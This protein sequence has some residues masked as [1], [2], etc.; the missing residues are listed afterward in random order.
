MQFKMQCVCVQRL[1][2]FSVFLVLLYIRSLDPFFRSVPAFSV[3]CPPKRE[4]DTATVDQNQTAPPGAVVMETETT[5]PTITVARS[6]KEE[7]DAK[8][9]GDTAEE[10]LSPP[11]PSSRRKHPP[12]LVAPAT[13]HFIPPQ[14]L[15]GRG[16]PEKDLGSRSLPL[17][18]QPEKAEETEGGEGKRESTH[19]QLNYNQLMKEVC[20]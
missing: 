4:E 7:D 19:S 16:E 11:Q 15:M 5:P 9:E 20:L 3:L 14:K 8:L 1:L 17:L 12:P 13:Y 6:P 2:H 10:S 18:Q